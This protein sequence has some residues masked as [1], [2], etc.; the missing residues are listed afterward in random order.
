MPAD[1]GPNPML[2]GGNT[3]PPG[4]GALG[5][6]MALREDTT[7][8]HRARYGGQLSRRLAAT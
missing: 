3:A 2:G 7:K 4:E 6:V 1:M 5:T 8:G